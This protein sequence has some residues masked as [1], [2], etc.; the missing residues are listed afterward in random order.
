MLEKTKLFETVNDQNQCFMLTV[1][2]IFLPERAH[3]PLF[4]FL[5]SLL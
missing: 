1:P 4:R 3:I 2:L 5:L